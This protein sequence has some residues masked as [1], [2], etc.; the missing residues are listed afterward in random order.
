MKIGILGGTF[1][2]IHEGH[3][4]IARESMKQFRLDK[5]LFVPARIPPHKKEDDQITPPAYRARMVE[6]ATV[7]EP[8]W[9]LCDLEL[10]RPGVSYTVDTLRELRKKFPPPHELFF[11]AGADSLQ[12]LQNWK[13]P[14]E[15]FK[16]S[17]WIVAP[18]PSF[19]VPESLSP[20]VHV[21]NMP[22]VDVSAR[23][24]RQKILQGDDVSRWIPLKALNYIQQTK[25]Y[26]EA[27][28]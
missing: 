18:R 3:L 11:I 22:P 16:L 10:R 28:R 15:I 24:L 25:I 13:E 6:L 21:L 26:G 4:T 19:K 7:E 14:E 23:E 20:R 5:I 12:D 1:D 27:L 9:E 2:P 8:R 17:E